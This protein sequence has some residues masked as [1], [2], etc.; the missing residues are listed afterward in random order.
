ML[1]VENRSAEYLGNISPKHRAQWFPH[2]KANMPFRL[3]RTCVN[4]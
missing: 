3:V 4:I 1:S 2:P